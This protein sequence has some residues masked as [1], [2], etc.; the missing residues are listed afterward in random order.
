VSAPSR[1]VRYAVTATSAVYALALYAAGFRFDD[2]TRQVLAYLPVLAV[3]GVIAFDLWVWKWPGI[4]RLAQRPRI[5]GAWRATLTPH[6]NSHIPDG[7]NRGPIEAAV[8]VE[9]TYWSVSVTLLTAESRSISTSAAIHNRTRQQSVLM[10]TYGN[11]PEQQHRPRSQPHT[12][13]SH[14]D[15]AGRDP[16]EMTGSYWTARLT[17]G[18]MRLTLVD[19][20]TNYPSLATVI[21]AAGSS[22]SPVTA[23]QAR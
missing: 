8:L 13:A 7:G 23:T 2:G 1:P 4:H 9:Q 10:Y 5:D 11:E 18:D 20:K 19:R 15:I 22:E 17:V 6:E 21:A 3:F 14:F 16:R 12:G